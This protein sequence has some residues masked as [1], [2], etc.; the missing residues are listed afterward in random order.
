MTKSRNS[1][2]DLTKFILAVLVVA[3]HVRPFS[4]EAAF[5]FDDCIAQM[6]DPLFFIITAYFFF[7]RVI[8]EQWEGR[9]L[10]RYL[11]RIGILYALWVILYLPVI[12]SSCRESRDTLKGQIFCFLQKIFLAG[13]YGAL[14]FLTALFLAVP[15]AYYIGRKWGARVC[16]L[17]SAPF[18]LFTALEMSY[19]GLV[20]QYAALERLR[21]SFEQVFGW[22][23]NGLNYGFFF[24]ALG[25]LAAEK[26]HRGQ[27]G[28]PPFAGL[29]AAVV[30]RFLECYGTRGTGIAIGY[31]SGFA[32]IFVAWFG[33]MALLEWDRRR[34]EHMAAASVAAAEKGQAFCIFLQKMSILIFTMHYGMMEFFQKIWSQWDFYAA[35]TTV[36]YIW[37]LTVCFVLAA[38]VVR[39]SEKPGLRFLKYLY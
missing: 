7:S 19:R 27:R 2:I 17:V 26:E 30:F 15:L 35:N 33:L 31:G 18:Y 24:C 16:V 10:L 22:L 14:W 4:G 39:L 6:A 5:F 13:P 38:G 8:K 28:V 34:K 20:E 37:I 36:Q 25:L 23:A 21:I 11:K 3:I 32:Q 1:G 29:A 9:M 12:L